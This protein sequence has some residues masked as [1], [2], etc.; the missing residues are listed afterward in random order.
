MDAETEGVRTPQF[1]DQSASVAFGLSRI[2]VADG[3]PLRVV[4]L[5]R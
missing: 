4:H 3:G 1:A 5:E 2:A